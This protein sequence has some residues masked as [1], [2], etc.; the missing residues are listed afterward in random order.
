MKK[1]SI[2]I[3]LFFATI[4]G[5]SQVTIINNYEEPLTIAY[6]YYVYGA[7]YN[8]WYSEGWLYLEPGQF[9]QVLNYLPTNRYMYYYAYTKNGKKFEGDHAMLVEFDKKF[10]IKNPDKA[11]VKTENPGYSWVNFC[12]AKLESKNVNEQQ[13]CSIIIREKAKK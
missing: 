12:E 13:Q 5:K 9:K 11:Y 6:V 7:D 8:G 1:L 10:K 3:L 4:G 2:L